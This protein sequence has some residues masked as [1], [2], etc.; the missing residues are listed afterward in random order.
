MKNL[1][2]ILLTCSSL[3]LLSQELAVNNPINSEALSYYVEADRQTQS[4]NVSAAKEL[5]HKAIKAQNDFVEALDNLAT[6]YKD[7]FQ[8]DSA[9]HFFKLSVTAQPNGL[10]ARHNM[11]A[12]YQ[13]NG[14][15][16]GAIDSYKA[17]LGYYPNYPEAYYGMAVSYLNI[18]QYEEAIKSAESAMRLYMNTDQMRDAAD[19]R[20]LAARVLWATKIIR[21]L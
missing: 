4:G 15:Y 9:M 3:S 6:L 14:D 5:Y 17:L 18:N 21:E 8:M 20:I 12:I 7:E 16:I 10:L 13:L 19:A 2:L 1:I 11:A